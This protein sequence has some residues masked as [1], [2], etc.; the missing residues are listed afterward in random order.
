MA[1]LGNIQTR[2]VGAG[3]APVTDVA[4][5][6]AVRGA[7]NLTDKVITEVAEADL[8]GTLQEDATEALTLSTDTQPI[9]FKKEE[10]D[11]AIV[12]LTNELR[13]HQAT[14]AQANNTN[15]RV[16]AQLQMQRSLQEK[17]AKYPWLRDELDAE[18]R[19]FMGMSPELTELGLSDASARAGKGRAGTS[20]D[21]LD[22]VFK[23]A[24]GSGTEDFN[25]DP[26]RFPIGTNEFSK[27]WI[28]Q[29]TLM[30]ARI[31]LR[32][33]EEMLVAQG[34]VT[35]R[36]AFA[37][38][39]SQLQ[40]SEG[41]VQA[42]YNGI[43]RQLAPLREAQSQAARDQ[44]P[45]GINS[46]AQAQQLFDTTTKPQINDT[47]ALSLR[48]LDQRFNR[49]FK[50][51]TTEFGTVVP[52]SST[53]FEAAKALY[54]SEKAALVTIQDLINSDNPNASEILKSYSFIRGATA[55]SE[56]PNMQ[57]LADL[58]VAH[59]TLFNNLDSLGLDKS[60]Q[61][62]W[63]NQ[64]RG[65]ALAQEVE[66]ALTAGRALQV[67]R[68]ETSKATTSSDY[69]DDVDQQRRGSDNPSGVTADGRNPPDTVSSGLAQLD[70][71]RNGF[72][73]I[74]TPEFLN[75]ASGLSYINGT[76]DTI[77]NILDTGA[78]KEPEDKA[79]IRKMMAS[80]A[81]ITA[82]GQIPEGRKD[83]RVA[84]MSQRLEEYWDKPAGDS[85]VRWQR[86][87]QAIAT[88]PLSPS[89][90][91][92]SIGSIPMVRFLDPD[93]SGLAENGTVT[94]TVRRSRVEKAVKNQASR[95]I[96]P[97]LLGLPQQDKNLVNT[98][99]R[100]LQRA[101]EKLSTSITQ[102]VRVDANLNWVA[103]PGTE[104]NYVGAFLQGGEG[105]SLNSFL[106]AIP[107]K[108]AQLAL[109]GAE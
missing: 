2:D 63:N 80:S 103:R 93:V 4:G 100:Q 71:M 42:I 22:S 75:Q 108:E 68:A 104:I 51:F 59:P 5:Q 37:V 14:A 66:D 57:A 84:A 49:L 50:P 106:R 18:A 99:V 9:E 8:R 53:A 32:D 31:G 1:D 69:L 64:K 60:Y 72:E 89:A 65:P 25:M 38:L 73:T 11:G 91:G 45:A 81:M 41:D 86:E 40:S 107:E 92:A 78:I 30:G 97:F 19:Q 95:G 82:V 55:I 56:A 48:E 13:R 88:N 12:E 62:V 54:L 90:S 77:G 27:E 10:G 24:Y 7:L 35:A 96:T 105:N 23:R 79:E 44:T 15:K 47:I 94:F 85:R 43:Q 33:K 87:I 109:N 6:N 52:S 3:T 36:E 58:T 46:L 101:A 70:A 28:R 16:S 17:K 83:L 61:S 20:A 76:I 21:V 102:F 26:L 34:N 98:L 74:T 29:Q 39:Q 67:Y